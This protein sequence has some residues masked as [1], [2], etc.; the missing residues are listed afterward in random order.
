MSTHTLPGKVAV[1]AGGA[2]NLGGHISRDLAAGGAKIV[3]HY[4]SDSTR[5]D[6]EKT[7]S[8]I[9]AA[10]GEGIIVQG[11]LTVVENVTALFDAAIKAFGKVDIAINTAG[12]VIKKPL[13]D[14]TE[15]DYDTSFAINS[16]AAFFFI[17]EAGKKLA[18]QGK[19]CTILTSLL[20]AYTGYYSAYA[21]SKAP[22]EHFTRAAAKEFGPR[23]I[24]VTAIAPG[25][26]ETPF[27]YGQETEESAAYLQAAADLSKFTKT[28]LTDPVDIMNIVRFI[29]TEGWWING[30]T[31]LA[32]G[33]FTTK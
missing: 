16:K 12:I 18:D 13:T 10:G 6:A 8:D 19:L 20:G 32:N 21:G 25:P 1:I 14:V 2:K 28:G 24:S 29:V 4:H 26:M 3:I 27:F 15:A 7:L 11:D 5:S 31:I 30:Q 17:Q 22:V 9:T 33:G 23:G